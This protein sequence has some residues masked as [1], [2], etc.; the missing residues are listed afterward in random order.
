MPFLVK[1]EL[2]F[3][4]T[5]ELIGEPQPT[6]EEFDKFMRE[7]I[8]SHFYI[9][10]PRYKEY[11]C[12]LFDIYCQNNDTPKCSYKDGF[13]EFKIKECHKSNFLITEDIYEHL[14]NFPLYDTLFEGSP[15][16]EAIYP[17]PI[18]PDEEIGVVKFAITSVNYVDEEN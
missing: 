7:E 10:F 2:Y 4:R 5:T 3:S 1:L 13:V 9:T 18:F 17:S 8:P 6:D 12:C 11:V 14:E 16:N 15:G